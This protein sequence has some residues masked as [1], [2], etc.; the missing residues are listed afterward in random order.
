MNHLKP[1]LP[2]LF[3]VFEPEKEI[4]WVDRFN[5]YFHELKM[6]SI[7]VRRLVGLTPGRTRWNLIFRDYNQ[8]AI[9]DLFLP[10]S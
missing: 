1:Y 3:G 9:K 2:V 10:Q 6:Y 7:V 8:N 5:Q 4:I